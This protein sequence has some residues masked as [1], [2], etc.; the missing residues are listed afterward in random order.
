[1]DGRVHYILG[2][3]DRIPRDQKVWLRS[4]H[5]PFNCSRKLRH[6]ASLLKYD[7]CVRIWGTL[8]PLQSTSCASKV[9]L[10]KGSCLCATSTVP[11]WSDLSMQD[12]PIKLLINSLPDVHDFWAAHGLAQSAYQCSNQVTDHI[13]TFW[14]TEGKN[15][16]FPKRLTKPFCFVGG[17][18]VAHIFNEFV[19]EHQAELLQHY[20]IINLTGDSTS[21]NQAEGAWVDYVTDKYLP[22]QK[23][24]L[25]VTRGGAN[26]IWLLYEQT[27]CA[28]RKEASRGDQIENAQYFVDKVMQSN[29][30]VDARNANETI[31]KC[32]AK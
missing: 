28:A 31:Q 13:P 1:M 7:G 4:M 12:W 18:A 26:T 29:W 24:D 9:L 23:A 6:L 27:P 17:S 22:C 11:P 8:S 25:V 32:W 3:K 20:N 5:F 16:R 10:S 30:E 14:R 2:T 19:T 15:K 21:L